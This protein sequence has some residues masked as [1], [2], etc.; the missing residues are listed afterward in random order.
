M[1]HNIWDNVEYVT[2]VIRVSLTR[3][4]VLERL[5]RS[6]TTAM[7]RRLKKFE[8]QHRI[9]TSH[10]KPYNTQKRRLSTDNNR[11]LSNED[12]FRV[13][14]KA[15]QAVV[16]RRLMRDNLLAYKC[17]RC[18]NVGVWNDEPLVLQLEH[19]DGDHTNN[20]LSNLCFLCPNCHSQT[21]TYCGKNV[22][23]KTSRPNKSDY[24]Q[25]VKD[26]ATKRNQHLVEA[27]LNS[28]IDFSRYGWSKQVASIINKTPQKVK[29]WMMRYMK[30][31][32]E[33]KCFH[34]SK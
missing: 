27:V 11:L 30:E 12:I 33:T 4:E 21:S 23:Y 14:S 24:I 16:K 2:D 5:G 18:K 26:S 19:K 34:R 3:M 17:D 7:Y 28:G 1:S 32:Y 9:D 29:D 10:F 6:Q 13:N 31:F 22:E 15:S 8:E 25:Q 20:E